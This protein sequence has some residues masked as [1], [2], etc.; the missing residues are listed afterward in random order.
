MDFTVQTFTS[1]KHKVGASALFEYRPDIF[2]DDEMKQIRDNMDQEPSPAHY[3]IVALFENR[4]VGYCGVIEGLE[5]RWFIDWFSVHPDYQRA[6]VGSKLLINVEEWLKERNISKL[7]VE[8]CSCDG[9]SVARSF[10]TAKYFNLQKTEK[11]GYNL[12][13][14]KLTY[15]KT[16][17]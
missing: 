3:K 1:S 17:S 6:G 2:P 16:L 15:V 14:S 8:T 11:D 10:Y 13:H 12:G 4:V 5:G 7:Y 9:E